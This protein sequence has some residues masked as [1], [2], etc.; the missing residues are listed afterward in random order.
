MNSQPNH[1]H[2]NAARREANGEVVARKPDGT[3]F[4]HIA[5][6]KQAREGLDRARRV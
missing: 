3:P 1:N 5:E 6:L 4:D 2:Y